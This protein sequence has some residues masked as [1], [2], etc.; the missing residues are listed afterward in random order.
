MEVPGPSSFL[1]RVGHRA[2]V[3]ILTHPS[4]AAAAKSLGLGHTTLTA[5]LRITWFQALL[6]ETRRTL[7][8]ELVRAAVADGRTETPLAGK[9][10]PAEVPTA[11]SAGYAT[12]GGWVSEWERPRRFRL[13]LCRVR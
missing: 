5:W 10:Q 7:R 6:D 9:V 2:A 12:G 3:A 13:R 8:D 1:R 4:L 11:E